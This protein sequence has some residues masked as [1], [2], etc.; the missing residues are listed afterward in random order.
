MAD[1]EKGLPVRTENDLQQKVQVKIVDHID[2][3]GADKQTEV[4]EK[5]VHVRAFAADSDGTKVQELRSQEG[6]T[7]TN[8]DYDAATNKRPSSQATILHDRAASPGEAEQNFRPT[9]V[10]SSVDDAKC[11]DVAIRDEVGNPYTQNNPFPVTFEESEGEEVQDFSEDA[12][13][14]GGNTTHLY[15]VPD[16]KIFL[17]DQ[18]ICR[19]SARCKSIIE[20]GDGGASEVF[21]VKAA[22]FQSEGQS[23]GADIEFVRSVK[24]VGTANGTTVRITKENRDDDDAQSIYT[25]IVGLLKDA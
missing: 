9:G 7:L 13:A 17:L 16:G 15:V 1:I 23:K 20:I 14:A 21:A 22:G 10:A 2:P 12:V 24:V 8:G 18:L 19:A 25:T 6:H 4:S 5:L 11:A 3:E